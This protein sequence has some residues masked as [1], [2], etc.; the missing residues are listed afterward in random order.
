[1]KAYCINLDRRADRLQHMIGLLAEQGVVFERVAAVDGGDPSVADAAAACRAGMTGST[2][3]AAAYGCFQSHREAW[4]RLLASG[5]SHAIVLEDDLI[6]TA[7]FSAYLAEG[8]VPVDADLV[9]LEANEHRVQLD[10]GRGLAAYGRRLHR[11]RSR[12]A[13]CGAYV[14]S[15]PAAQH[16]LAATEVITDPVDE[17]LFNDASP[18]FGTMVIYQ[19]VPAPVM[20]GR[21]QEIIASGWWQ[22]SSIDML[23]N[24]NPKRKKGLVVRIQR[25]LS[26]EIRA[27]KSGM[28]Y[29]L[30]S[31]G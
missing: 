13:G 25:R 4:R 10:R 9:K 22:E 6:V 8:W 23:R 7:S 28:R 11:L 5:E 17:A 15:A 20:Q 21:R 18:L 30:V 14:I 26:G 1:M 12:H 24:P 29:V 19:M 16:L 31:F 27:L 3:S 2:M